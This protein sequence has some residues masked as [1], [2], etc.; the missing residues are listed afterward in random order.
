VSLSC[1]NSKTSEFWISGSK[2]VNIHLP[3]PPGVQLS[4][5]E[6]QWERLVW[7]RWLPVQARLPLIAQILGAIALTA[8]VTGPMWNTDTLPVT[9]TPPPAALAAPVSPMPSGASPVRPAHLNLDVRHAFGSA[10]FAVSVDGRQVI[11]TTLEG[12]GKR[13]K[14]FGKRGERNFTQTL[15]LDPGVRVVRVRMRSTGDKFD[16]TRTEAF[17]LGSASVAAMQISADKSGLSIVAQRPPGA[18]TAPAPQPTAAA[19]PPAA[20]AAAAPAP[21]THAAS[22]SIELLQ[23]VRAMLIAI[24][25]FVASAATGFVVQEFL[26]SRRGLIFA[27]A[28]EPA[29]ANDITE[30]GE[31]RRKRRRG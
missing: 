18:A 27:N 7:P 13:F 28:P 8:L 31:R 16:Q 2:G 21:Q 10:E 19:A 14:V 11:S 17:N 9:V 12:S 20:P 24:M 29:P 26:R 22:A 4:M 3:A 1:R 25:G 5:L 23:S 15:D 6:S 30:R